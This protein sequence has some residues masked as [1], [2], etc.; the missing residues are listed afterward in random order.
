MMPKM[1]TTV[2]IEEDVE[3]LLRESMHRNRVSFKQA[4]NDALR[5]GLRS[6]QPKSP[7]RKFVVQAR[8]MRLQ[9]GLDPAA[10]SDIDT[11]AELAEYRRKSE[12]LARKL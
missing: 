7:K 6:G 4:L 5:C 8:A 12:A 2:T 11:D 1:R 10:L 3:R 9:P